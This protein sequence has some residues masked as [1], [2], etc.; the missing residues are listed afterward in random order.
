M[1]KEK[2]GMIGKPDENGKGFQMALMSRECVVQKRE[3]AVESHGRADD[4]R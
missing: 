1:K 2:R 4:D 3:A